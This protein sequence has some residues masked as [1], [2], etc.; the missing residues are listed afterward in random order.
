MKLSNT[1]MRKYLWYFIVFA[2]VIVLFACGKAAKE[3]DSKPP[4]TTAD[5]AG[6]RYNFV[7]DV[8]LLCDDDTDEGCDKTYF[9][10]DG[11]DPITSTTRKQYQQ[12][13]TI[14]VDTSVAL[15]FFSIDKLGHSEAV[16]TERY[17]LPTTN[18]SAGRLYSLVLKEDDTA[19]AWGQ[20][21]VGQLG[22]GKTL[23]DSSSPVSVCGDV[24]CTDA[25]SDTVVIASGSYHA[26]AM[27]NNQTL[28]A[29]GGN[30]RGQLGYG[31]FETGGHFPPVEV[32]ALYNTGISIC[33]TKFSDI[34]DVIAISGGFEHS[35]ALE[36][37]GYVWAWGLND[38]GQLG[39]GEV[40]IHNCDNEDKCS[41]TPV[42]V[43]SITNIIAI[44]AG[45]GD[46]NLSKLGFS[47]ALED[48]GMVWAWG[49]NAQSQLGDGTISTKFTPVQVCASRESD[50][51]KNFLT[52]IIA[53]SSGHAHSLALKKD[54]TVWAW[55]DNEI[56]QLG[57][58][59]TE[60]RTT[61]VP[62]CESGATD[63][64]VES[65]NIL[66]DVIAIAGGAWH[67]IALKS[68]GTVWAWGLNGVGQL[69]VGDAN[70]DTC[71]YNEQLLKCSTTPMQVLNQYGGDAPLTD[72][73]AITSG[74]WHN[75]VL[76]RDRI[77]LTWGGNS[78]GQL[79]NDTY[80][81]SYWP[82]EV[83]DLH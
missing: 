13:N 79:G 61:P 35:L 41:K 66:T 70:L 62:I 82:V 27:K 11:S 3:K 8:E 43:E 49:H 48:N 38:V 20:N 18:I 77:I 31:E 17:S 46:T 68:D 72:I 2:F 6:G 7:Q 30:S 39:V 28:W 75:L 64:T 12:G 23:T 47:L 50:P 63:C 44:S 58:G 26:L 59:T 34:S 25:L 32:C 14:S 45:W 51:C 81:K 42:R 29:W 69:G 36:S 10:T 78:R 71:S 1:A 21:H 80:D 9:T 74:G 57:D 33:T 73:I 60:Q 52:G 24:D 4:V 19:W 22:D 53:L 83:F 54:G 15:R 65:Q 16:T 76:N 40:N 67:S 5:P 37:D 55:G 56:G